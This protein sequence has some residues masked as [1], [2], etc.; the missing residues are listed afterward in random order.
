MTLHNVCYLV[1]MKCAIT[2]SS[3]CTSVTITLLITG[4]IFSNI[5]LYVAEA[6]GANTYQTAV[7][8]QQ[9]FSALCLTYLLLLRPVLFYH[10]P[11]LIDTFVISRHISSGYVHFTRTCLVIT[12]LIAAAVHCYT[13][14]WHSF[15]SPV[16]KVSSLMMSLFGTQALFGSTRTPKTATDNNSVR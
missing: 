4:N 13:S 15:G 14:Y 1:N 3:K 12:T 7:S 16:Y 2:S 5:S 11:R 9:R 6:I 10:L 8:L